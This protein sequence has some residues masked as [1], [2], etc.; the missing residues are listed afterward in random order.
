VEG[1]IDVVEDVFGAKGAFQVA[2]AIGDELEAEAG[3]KV[4]DEIGA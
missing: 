2:V 4:E 3:F 1:S